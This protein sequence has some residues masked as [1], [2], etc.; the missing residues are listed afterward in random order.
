MT[1][2]VWRPA[3]PEAARPVLQRAE[4]EVRAPWVII[5]DLHGRLWPLDQARARWPGHQLLLLGDLLDRGPQVAQVVRRARELQGQGALQLLWGNHEAFHVWAAQGDGW[6]QSNRLL[7]GEATERSY[8]SAYGGRGG[9]SAYRSDLDWIERCAG[10]WA[11]VEVPGLGWLLAAHAWAPSHALLSGAANWDTP[12]KRRREQVPAWLA[13]HLWTRLGDEGAEQPREVEGYV[14][15]VHGHDPAPL[16]RWLKAG[17]PLGTWLLDSTEPDQ[18][19]VLRC[20]AA[21]SPTRDVLHQRR[22]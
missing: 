7:H 16:G 5:P 1:S 17:G 11:R 18:V 6:A 19:Q 2:S 20:D 3:V 14:G 8:L 15:L 13:E 9:G 4:L 21:G 10:P 12:V 22:S